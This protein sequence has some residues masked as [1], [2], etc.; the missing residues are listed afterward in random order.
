MKVLIA[1][2]SS[3]NFEGAIEY[4]KD[5]AWTPECKFKLVHIVQPSDVTDLW[6]SISGA[7]RFRHIL[8]ER[9]IEAKSESALTEEK[10]INALGSATELDSSITVGLIDE[11][12]IRTAR[13]W[14]A[15]V[16]IVGLP[17]ST[18][19]GRYTEGALLSRVL[20]EAPCPVLFARKH[21]ELSPRKTA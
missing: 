12:I 17:K 16:V 10:C 21:K 9:Q 20:A 18:F 13:E 11:V 19:L 5:G 6:L 1:A 15:D 4:L 2:D 3:E 8:S 14:E 7:T